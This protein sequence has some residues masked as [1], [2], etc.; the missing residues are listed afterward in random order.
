MEKLYC[1]HYIH[2]CDGYRLL[3]NHIL[4][5]YSFDVYGKSKLYSY[6]NSDLHLSALTKNNRRII[7]LIS[8][9]KTADRV[10]NHKSYTFDDILGIILNQFF[11]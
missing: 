9:F 7:Q 4:G 10:L 3:S 1:S 2:S 6:Y 8:V 5:S 11:K